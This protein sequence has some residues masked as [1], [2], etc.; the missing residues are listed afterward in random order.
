MPIDTLIYLNRT[1][2]KT[3]NPTTLPTSGEPVA[4][5]VHSRS[6]P[7]LPPELAGWRVIGTI[8]KNQGTWS[9]CTRPAD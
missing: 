7:K 5:I 8:F 4:V 6:D 2:A 1:V 9:A 3:T